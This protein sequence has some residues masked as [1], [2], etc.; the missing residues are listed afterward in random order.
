MKFSSCRV[1]SHMK[2]ELQNE[3]RLDR[4][5]FSLPPGMNTDYEH[6]EGWAWKKNSVSRKRYVE[7]LIR[8]L[9]LNIFPNVGFLVTQT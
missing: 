1:N 3:G 7:E 4:S 8:K 5:L 6:T 2:W 9:L